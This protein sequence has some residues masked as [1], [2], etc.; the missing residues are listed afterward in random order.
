[1]RKVFIYGLI[2]PLTNQIKYVGKTI[3]QLKKRLKCHVNPSDKDLTYRANWIRSLKNQGLKPTITLI[4]ECTENNWIEREVYWI[5]YYSKQ[6]ELTNYA[7]GG[8]GGHYVKISTREKLSLNYVEKWKNPEYKNTM[9]EMSK[10]LWENEEHK[11]NM[12][13]IK[14]QQWLDEDY[15]NKM[16]E[17][18]KKLWENEDYR[19]NRLTDE[20]KE[21]IRQA[22][23]GSTH[24]QE[25]KDLMS[26]KH[27]EFWANNKDYMRKKQQH[28]FTPI[29]VNNIKYTSIGEASRILG[30]NS[31]TIYRRVKSEKYPN[32]KLSGGN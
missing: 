26:I 2:C 8:N 24:T 3:Q 17:M 10:K 5:D 22:K 13:V 20:S 18:T 29:I 11:N 31:G 25:S 16:S 12:S 4:E 28:R 1:M 27:K 32:Y 21:K 19:N 23:L 30:I 9:R 6:F 15:R 7:K 14:K